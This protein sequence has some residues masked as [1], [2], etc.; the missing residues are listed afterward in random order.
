MN[1]DPDTKMELLKIFS[2]PDNAIAKVL[3]DIATESN[4]CTQWIYA[5]SVCGNIT[6]FLSGKD[7]PK[8]GAGGGIC[9]CAWIPMV[10]KR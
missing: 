9:V 8:P 7:T 2:N 10:E 6:K 4:G 5:L 1:G 3:K